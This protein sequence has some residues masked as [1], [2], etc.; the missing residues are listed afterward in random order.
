MHLSDSPYH[1]HDLWMVHVQA[2]RPRAMLNTHTA[3]T[4]SWKNLL[5]LSKCHKNCTAESHPQRCCLILTEWNQCILN[6]VWIIF[7]DQLHINIHLSWSI[8]EGKWWA[9]PATMENKR[10][11]GI[12]TIW[13]RTHAL[14]TKLSIRADF[15]D[16]IGASQGIITKIP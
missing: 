3:T 1:T 12:Y 10:A 7:Q 16:R 2:Q 5:D 8:R 6:S 13:S 11:Y 4:T 14:L 15:I 9:T